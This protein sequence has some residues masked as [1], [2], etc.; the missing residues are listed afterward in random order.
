M[1]E[2]F[3]QEYNTFKSNTRTKPKTKKRKVTRKTLEGVQGASHDVDDM[4]TEIKPQGFTYKGKKRNKVKK[5]KGKTPKPA[6]PIKTVKR[7][8]NKVK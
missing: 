7:K 8:T 4:G 5:K 1:E 3:S 6:K 2:K